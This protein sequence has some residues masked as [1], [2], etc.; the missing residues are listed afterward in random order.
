MTD[1]SGKLKAFLRRLGL[2][3]RR[4]QQCLRPFQPQKDEFLCPECAREIIPYIGPMCKLCGV[5]L[6][7]GNICQACKKNPPSWSSLAYFG[8]YAGLLRDML[9]RL[10][11]DGEL[12][13]ARF[14]G[15]TLLEAVARLPR[16]DAVTSIPQHNV[17]LRKRGF[18]QAHEIA[19]AFCALSGFHLES[20]LLTRVKE[21]NPQE[22]LNA[23]QRKAN[24][25]NAFMA[26]PRGV[27]KH[28]WIIDDILTTGATCEEASATL[29]AAGAKAVSLLV[30]A[31]TPL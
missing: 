2:D 25:A 23:A 29:L 5:P 17:K 28:I 15:Q 1:F 10:K 18:N 21:G 30:V 4:C 31:R 11:F 22:G 9:L 8:L 20:G 14:L 3:E 27:G 13:L 16:P 24:M 26:S 19:R 12:H 6:A 7:S